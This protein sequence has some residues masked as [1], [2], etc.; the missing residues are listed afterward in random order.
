MQQNR[1]AQGALASQVKSSQVDDHR[2]YN[3]PDWHQS[4]AH[5]W[6]VSINIYVCIVIVVYSLKK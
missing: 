3:F 1:K 4:V 2:N 6:I 5:F